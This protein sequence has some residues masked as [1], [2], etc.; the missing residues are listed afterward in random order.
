M[1]LNSGIFCYRLALERDMQLL[2]AGSLHLNQVVEELVAKG[3][4]FKIW[5][6]HNSVKIWIR[7]KGEGQEERKERVS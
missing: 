2:K 1:H 6:T 4:Q 5:F 7:M 3:I